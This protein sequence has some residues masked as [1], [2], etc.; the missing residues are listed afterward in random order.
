MEA[1][2]CNIDD[3]LNLNREEEGERIAETL[4]QESYTEE[5]S[6]FSLRPSEKG[7]QQ[8]M[9]LVKDSP[10]LPLEPS[11]GLSKKADTKNIA[12]Y[13]SRFVSR[14]M[15]NRYEGYLKARCAKAGVNWS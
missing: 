1:H 5:S 11:L 15:L 4:L 10:N 9:P 14:T 6:T 7:K 12:C 3:L 8:S 2:Y 13:V